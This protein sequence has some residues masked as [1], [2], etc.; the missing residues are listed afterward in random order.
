MLLG[1]RRRFVRVARVHALRDALRVRAFQADGRGSFQHEV[2]EAHRYR[3]VG[4]EVFAE[5]K[6]AL[7]SMSGQFLERLIPAFAT[8]AREAREGRVPNAALA[9]A[10]GGLGRE[11]LARERVCAVFKNNN[12]QL[13]ET[14]ARRLPDADARRN[15][16]PAVPRFRWIYAETLYE[17]PAA[18]LDDLREA[19][20]TL[21]DTA[22][23]AR[24]VLGGS[25]PTTKGIEGELQNARAVHRARD[26][27]P[28][29]T[30]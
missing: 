24:R 11:H 19:V 14:L 23:T 21:D 27:P 30:V 29:G 5:A 26:T 17:D 2:G 8:L 3:D 25:H 22:R 20:S 18:T 15:R 7:W 4:V 9:E 1:P 6:D 10:G 16:H 12:R 13:W 28:P